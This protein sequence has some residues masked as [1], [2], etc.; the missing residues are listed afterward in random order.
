MSQDV[1]KLLSLDGKVAMVTGAA[2][3]F[4]AHFARTLAAAGA[5]VVCTARRTDRIE[6]VA[7]AIRQGGGNAIAVPMDVTGNDSV[8]QAFAAAE[9]AFGVVDV[10]VNNAGQTAY[11]PFFEAD[12]EAWDRL[13]D[14]NL[15]G[16][17]RVARAATRRM[18][19][20]DKRGA[21]INIASILSFLAKSGFGPYGAAKGAVLQLTRTMALDLLD[22]G[23]RV[24]AIAPGYFATE[25]TDWYFE[26]DIGRSD[27]E[28][29]PGKR[30]G[31]LDELDGPL[32]L[33]ASDA[34]SHMNGSVITVDGGH[35]VRLS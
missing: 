12:D 2:S 29:L 21:I 22:H 31:R 28:T 8:E 3:G 9:A 34:S 20:H 16:V 14:V 30:L 33:L 5:S 24:N 32:L 25:M 23:I 35:S 7:D 11:G 26:S 19:A 27:I 10:L 6:A 15:K 18:I 13:M 4:G 1:T 17:W